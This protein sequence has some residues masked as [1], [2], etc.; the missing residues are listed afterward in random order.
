MS[1]LAS[2]AYGLAHLFHPKMLWLMAWPMVVALLTWGVVALA[3]WTRT[4]LWLADL[5][6]RY[7]AGAAA[8]VNLDVGNIALILANILLILLFVPLV[9]LTALFLLGIFG[10]NAMV[11][12]VAER[13]FP[14]LERRRGGGTTG[15][16][17]N[18][19]VAFLGMLGLFL[20]SLPLWV[21][22][23]LWPVIP[24]LVLAWVNQRLLRYDAL[25]EH[26]DRE[27][28]RALFRERR[29]TLY[30]LGAVMALCAFVPL[31][32]FLVPVAFGL[33][34]IHYLLG[35]L[36]DSRALSKP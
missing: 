7:T 13:S 24:V 26:A 27:E 1:A 16:A 15:S 33:A 18:A 4:A 28:M 10:M 22:P 21:F 35:A 20:V 3:V 31:A 36:Q 29:G 14:A 25:A 23:P 30:A 17:F 5:I 11:D 19:L 12:Y 9:Y 8:T 2:L 32:G 34:Y 6:V